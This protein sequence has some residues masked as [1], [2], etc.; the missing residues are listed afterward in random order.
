MFRKLLLAAAALWAAVT[1]SS[2][3]GFS[4]VTEDLMDPPKLTAEQTAINNALKQSVISSTIRLKYPKTGDYRS[5]FVF[6]DIDGDDEQEAI[7][8]Y[9]VESSD[10]TRVSLLDQKEGQWVAVYELP[11]ASEDVEFISFANITDNPADDVIIGWS[12][13]DQEEKELCVYS[14]VDNTL[15]LQHSETYSEYILDDLDRDGRDDI[16]IVHKSGNS[17]SASLLQISFNGYEVDVVSEISLSDAIVEF[18]HLITGRFR[19]DS[20]Q[21]AL[22]IDELIS[23]SSYAT[24]VFTITSNG[25]IPLI[26]WEMAELDLEE[27]Q[28]SEELKP[29]LSLYEQTIRSEQVFCTDINNDSVVEIPISRSLPGYED[30]E[31]A[32]A[33]KLYLTQYCHLKDES[34]ARV[35]SA[36]IN[37]T[38]GYMIRFPENWIDNVTV[39][40]QVENGEWRFIRYNN[41]LKHSLND[42][43]EELARI[44]VVSQNDY[45]DKFLENYIELD[46]KGLFTYYGY[47]PENVTSDLKISAVELKSMFELI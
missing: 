41:E 6:H 14:M 29:T 37:R 10:Y 21:K 4:V 16:F 47:I 33:D 7:A 43:S 5:S 19:S 34:F 25:L 11:G 9:S 13:P 17:R 20:G 2:C 42:I 26:S 15:T 8:F 40:N 45:Q 12:S 36:V 22:F 27:E 1:L 3:T 46:V 35:F 31:L 39:V 28:P 23:G 24:E 44:R 32:E 38:A 18:S 30:E